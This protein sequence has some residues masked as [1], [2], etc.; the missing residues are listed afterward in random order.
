[1]GRNRVGANIGAR[2]QWKDNTSA[3][4]NVGAYYN[5][6]NP[7]SKI[8]PRVELGVSHRFKDGGWL[9]NYK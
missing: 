7:G 6:Y 5:P 3:N 9:N 1:M 8:V 2:A 4:L